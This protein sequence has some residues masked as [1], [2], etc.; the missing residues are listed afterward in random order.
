MNPE[1]VVK[2]SLDIGA[3]MLSSG[4]ETIRVEDTVTRICKSYYQGNINVTSYLSA[5]FVSMEV[6]DW[7]ENYSSPHI[8]TQHRRVTNISNQLGRLEDLNALSRYICQYKPEAEEIES[9]LQA[10]LSSGMSTK[11][12]VVGYFLAAGSFSVF[13]GGNLLDGFIGGLVSLVLYWSEKKIKDRF[14]N[15]LVRIFV[16]SF[17]TGLVSCMLHLCTI[18]IHTDKVMIGNVMLLIPG[19]SLTNSLRDLFTGDTASGALK[20]LNSI[21]LAVSIAI[22][23]ALAMIITGV[24]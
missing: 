22:G 5:L 16:L 11:R 2:L 7:N 13:F 1:L 4:A 24:I 12:G 9:R 14:H 8:V 19:V 6:P 23:F 3:A 17:I 21:L 10:I 18:P 15:E 20:L